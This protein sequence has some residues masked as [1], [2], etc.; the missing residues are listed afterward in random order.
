MHI[1][2]KKVN[3]EYELNIPPPKNK[4][5]AMVDLK[6]MKEELKQLEDPPLTV[7][8]KEICS[9]RLPYSFFDCPCEELAQSL[10]GNLIILNLLFV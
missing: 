6:M 4:A 2:K 8:E 5:R 9:N 1:G 10:L 7:W 3:E